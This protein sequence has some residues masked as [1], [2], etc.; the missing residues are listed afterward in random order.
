MLMKNLK[1]KRRITTGL[2][3]TFVSITLEKKLFAVLLVFFLTLNYLL[4]FLSIRNQINIAV[5]EPAPQDIIVPAT[6]SY[7]DEAKTAQAIE[8]AKKSVMPLYTYDSNVEIE[9]QNRIVNLFNEILSIKED[10]SKTKNPPM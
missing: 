2:K 7:I 5:N 10:S 8:N 1:I 3:E 9:V 4:L 6:I